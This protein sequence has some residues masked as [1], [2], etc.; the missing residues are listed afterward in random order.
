[1]LRP[2]ISKTTTTTLRT[3]SNQRRHFI[4]STLASL[5]TFTQ[6]NFFQDMRKVDKFEELDELTNV[7]TTGKAEDVSES[8]YFPDGRIKLNTAEQAI[9]FT[10]SGIN[11]FLHPEVGANVN[12]FGEVS[13]FTAILANMRDNMLLSES[14]RQILRE[15]PLMN[16]TTLDPQYLCKLPENTLG[17]QYLKFTQ[18]GDERAPVKFIQDEE[19][20]YVFL[21]YRQIHDIAHILT[22]KKIDLAGELPVKAF[23]FGNTGLPMTGLACFAYFK[24]SSKRKSN[25]HMLDSLIAGLNATPLY[26]VYWEKMMERDVDELRKELN[27]RL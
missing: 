26:T 18:D 10:F 23:E 13:A 15:R 25:V 22:D 5:A 20:A 16:S 6:S 27:I 9:L 7:T 19:L 2:I 8:K 11:A 12:T 21:R 17:Y 24:L 3:V 4:I 1:M 14:G